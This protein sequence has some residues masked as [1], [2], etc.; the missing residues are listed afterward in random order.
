MNWL[1]R[2]YS[3]TTLLAIPFAGIVLAVVL[4]HSLYMHRAGLRFAESTFFEINDQVA[5]GVTAELDAV[6]ETPDHLIESVANGIEH[7]LIGLE[8]PVQL[9]A[10]LANELRPRPWIANLAWAAEDGESVCAYRD[11]DDP[12]R[13]MLSRVEPDRAMHSYDLDPAGRP[14]ERIDVAADF[15]ARTRP[16]YRAALE[17]PETEWFEPYPF[18]SGGSVGIG[19]SRR[20]ETPA[21]RS[22]VVAVDVS[23]HDVTRFLTS[24]DVARHGVAFVMTADGQLLA[25]SSARPP[26]RREGDKTRVLHASESTLPAVGRIA[27]QAL[28]SG[29][30]FRGTIS[31]DEAELL[32]NT[33][34]YVRDGGLELIIGIGVPRSFYMPSLAEETRH[35]LVI[36]LLVTVGGMLFSLLV[37]GGVSRPVRRMTDAMARVAE[38]RRHEKIPASR[39]REIH[40]LGSTFAKMSNRLQTL[41]GTLESRVRERTSALRLANEKLEELSHTDELTGLPNRRRLAGELAREWQRAIREARPVSLIMCDIDWFKAYNDTLGHP[42]GDEALK[43][44]AAALADFGQRGTDLVARIGGEEFIFML[45]DTDLKAASELAERAREAVEALAIEHPTAPTGRMTISCGVAS[46]VPDRERTDIGPTDLMTQA[47]RALYRAKNDGR[48]R[49][50][51]AGPVAVSG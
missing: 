21:G 42:E 27:Q 7:G 14:T 3:L 16:W 24:L 2:S 28:A 20:V 15:D 38:G 44:V 51:A 10:R 25:D 36:A 32:V 40:E 13:I 49:V 48:N 45:P 43:R 31:F 9:G 18:F 19:R 47:D 37:A 50:H 33:R 4:V 39:I 8:D 35:G 1:N 6:F 17:T 26:L 30:D 23:L 22:G 12:D 34:R 11:W 29:A 5:A 41:L 46:A